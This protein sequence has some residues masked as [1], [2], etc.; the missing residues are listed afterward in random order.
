MSQTQG[1]VRS[2]SSVSL[3]L[4]ALTSAPVMAAVATSDGCAATPRT[5]SVTAAGAAH[6][7]ATGRRDIGGASDPF[8]NGPASWVRLDI[9]DPAAKAADS[10]WLSGTIAGG[11]GSFGIDAAAW[12]AFD[13]LAIGFKRQWQS[14]RPRLGRF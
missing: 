9:A 5:V 13:H 8:R 12:A 11:H 2:L 3:C 4:L 14:Q 1:L 6:C 10:G 7:V